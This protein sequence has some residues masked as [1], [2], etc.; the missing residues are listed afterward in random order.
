MTLAT[1]CSACGTTFK[2]VQDQLKVSGGWVRCGRCS[3][4]FNAIDGLFEIAGAASAAP[5]QPPSVARVGEA[6]AGPHEARLE[7][8]A[9]GPRVAATPVATPAASQQTEPGDGSEPVEWTGGAPTDQPAQVLH[10]TPVAVTGEAPTEAAV[11]AT[12]AAGAD[13]AF[14]ARVETASA[15][16]P[17]DQGDATQTP[18][19]ATGVD[20]A[21]PAPVPSASS[22]EVAIA[23]A[24]GAAA[25]ASIE[26]V[27]E[28][29]AEPVAERPFVPA[30][31]HAA[32]DLPA[33]GMAALPAD[34]DAGDGLPSA[35][36]QTIASAP[37]EEAQTDWEGAAVM[38]AAEGA[39][40]PQTPAFLRKA[41]RAARW[42]RPGVRR[43][44]AAS[45]GV[46][47]LL[48]GLQI[49]IAWRD[50]IAARWPAAQP[51]LVAA[52]S[53][54]GCAIEPLRRIGGLSVD[55]SGLQQVPGTPIYRLSLV[56]RNRADLELMLPAIE[57][58]LTDARGDVVVRRVLTAAELGSSSRTI[59]A[60]HEL[61]LEA[62]LNAGDRRITGYTIETFYP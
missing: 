55:A 4:V 9:G 61:A 17:A 60:G 39:A 47:A 49:T 27:A 33:A 5:P 7:A 36:A 52:C 21:M 30:P 42:R 43:V 22:V 1:R 15:A 34:A 48:L 20:I 13:W 45:V 2:V 24:A 11:G 12:G 25:Q 44:L 50:A 29:V 14:D 32:A 35:R 40:A 37:R 31:E 62:S 53:W 51:L 26:P 41:E 3:E 54:A 10:G 57:L 59:A 8:T 18:A 58:T 38:S 19:A 16:H 46:L 28:S 23:A 6:A 56:L